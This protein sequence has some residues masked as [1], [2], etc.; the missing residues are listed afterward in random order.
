M[1][2][3]LKKR[4]NLTK[5]QKILCVLLHWFNFDVGKGGEDTFC[6]KKH[7]IENPLQTGLNNKGYLLAHVSKNFWGRKGSGEVQSGLQFSFFVFFLTLLPS[8][9][10]FCFQSGFPYCPII[11]ARKNG[12]T[13]FFLS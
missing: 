2:I 1:S 6:W 7:E 3:L 4:E 11:A 13:F 10:Q 12:A 8:R 9:F 5:K